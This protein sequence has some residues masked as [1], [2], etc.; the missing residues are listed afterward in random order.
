MNFICLTLTTSTSCHILH[1]SCQEPVTKVKM[2]LQGHQDRKYMSLNLLILEDN[3]HV[4]YTIFMYSL[5]VQ[6]VM[7][8]YIL[9]S[10]GT[11]YAAISAGSGT[12]WHK[13][14]LA[15]DTSAQIDF[16]TV[17]PWPGTPWPS[18]RNT[19]PVA[20]N[21][22]RTK[23]TYTH[24]KS[25]F[26]INLTRNFFLKVKCLKRKDYHTIFGVKSLKLI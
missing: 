22:K 10:H 23:H 7:C 21:G 8:L 18:Y 3:L 4:E 5:S 15:R 12:P 6:Y 16:F 26:H 11:F 24:I 1:K 25:L 19:L 13:T 9:A 14:I 20:N 17:T 2:N